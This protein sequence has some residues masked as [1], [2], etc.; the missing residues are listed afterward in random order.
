MITSLIFQ[1]TGGEKSAHDNGVEKGLRFSWGLIVQAFD[2]GV[3][4]DS[5]LMS[6]ANSE[7]PYVPDYIK[8]MWMRNSLPSN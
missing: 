1:S 2:E 6:L 7:L 8:C 4:E 5:E 3:E